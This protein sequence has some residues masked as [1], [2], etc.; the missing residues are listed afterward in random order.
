MQVHVGN[1]VSRF[2]AQNESRNSLALHVHA[3]ARSGVRMGHLP[4][5]F[6]TLA[7]GL[8]AAAHLGVV[9]HLLAVISAALAD[10]GAYAAGQRVKFGSADH[11]IGAGAADLGAIGHET[12]VIAAGMAPAFSQAVL[13]RGD[14]DGV[15]GRAVLDALPH[16]G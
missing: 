3:A 10:L 16:F 15:T 11:E 8:D 1:S 7:A 6:G 14:A 5:R 9:G 2:A 13:D 4:A 12:N